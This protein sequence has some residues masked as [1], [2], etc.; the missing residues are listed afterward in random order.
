M[1]VAGG[2]NQ[3][4]NGR[5]F[6]LTR[7]GAGA[8]TRVRRA[9]WWLVSQP[10]SRAF[11]SREGLQLANARLL[12]PLEDL[13]GNTP[14]TPGGES[15]GFHLLFSSP[16]TCSPGRKPLWGPG[17]GGPGDLILSLL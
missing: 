11:R 10:H 1:H 6:S 17:S 12:L 14:P 4:F 9:L 8:T 3:D 16:R 2:F 5:L 7:A 15:F 13:S